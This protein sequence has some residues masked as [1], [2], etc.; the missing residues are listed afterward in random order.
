[1]HHPFAVA[2]SD[3]VILLHLQIIHRFGSLDCL[4]ASYYPKATISALHM[5]ADFELPSGRET[6]LSY[7]ERMLASGV[8][9]LA[10][11]RRR[12]AI[13]GGRLNRD[14]KVY[15]IIIDNLCLS[16]W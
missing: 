9:N 10:L 15:E 14:R 11:L 8:N 3:G 12:F 2:H 7:Q 5:H 16:S 6:L 13:M 1:M 4:P